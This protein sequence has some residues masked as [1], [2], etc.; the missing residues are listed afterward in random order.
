MSGYDSYTTTFT[1]E[2]RLMQ[3]EYAMERINKEKPTVGIL[4]KDGVILATERREKHK[5]QD[6]AKNQVHKIDDHVFCSVS[7]NTADATPLIDGARTFSQRF[8]YTYNQDSPVEQVVKHVC[9]EKHFYTQFGSYRP[10]GVHFMYA[11]FDDIEGFQLYSSD[12][13]GNYSSW[14]AHVTGQNTAAAYASS[15]FSTSINPQT[16]LK[17]DFDEDMSF[18]EGLKLAVKVVYKAID[19]HEPKGDRFEVTYITKSDTGLVQK[20]L[21]V[22]KIEAI[23]E[24]IKKEEEDEKVNKS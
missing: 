2:G 7:G 16:I 15:G 24:V 5:L 18:E 13:S 11:G 9:E 23:I 22:E 4:T 3:I 1:P 8:T 19:T 20:E 14:K 21:E 17:C 12:P 10:L 6:G